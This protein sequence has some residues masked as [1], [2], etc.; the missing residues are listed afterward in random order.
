MLKEQLPECLKVRKLKQKGKEND[1]PKE[2]K[3]KDEIQRRAQ[4]E[5]KILKRS[6]NSLKENRN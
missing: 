1:M 3:N 4:T 5:E 2:Q 6:K